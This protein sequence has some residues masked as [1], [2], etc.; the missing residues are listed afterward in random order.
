MLGKQ[1]WR[2][3]T[4]PNSLVTRMYKAKYYDSDIFH[5]QLSHNLSFIWRSLL[6]AKQLLKDG[7]RWRVG[8]RSSISI[9]NHPC[10][11]LN[12]NPYIM[13]MLEPLQGKVVHRCYALI[14]RNGIGRWCRTC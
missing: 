13:S 5:A 11:T 3:A 4:N 14:K 7:I 2:L 10:L 1:L 12:D 6:E 9:L 8:D